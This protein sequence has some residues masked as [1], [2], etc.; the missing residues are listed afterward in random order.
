SQFLS[1]LTPKHCDSPAM[2]TFARIVP[3]LG[4]CLVANGCASL[5][6]G[7]GDE[8]ETPAIALPPSDARAPSVD[9]T[10]L[11]TELAQLKAENARLRTAMKALQRAKIAAEQETTGAAKTASGGEPPSAAAASPAPAAGPKT[12]VVAAADADR[13]LADAPQVA[14]APR[15]VQPSI[16]DT[17]PAFENEAAGDIK[18]A[19]VLYGVHLASYRMTDEAREGWRKLQR[20][21]PDELGLLEPRVEQV[22]VN[23]RGVFLRLIGGGF[24]SE[25]KAEA[26]CKRLKS[27]NLYCAVASFNGDRLSLAGAA[28]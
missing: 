7:G 15:L 27:K 28:G 21:N 24:S 2:N 20:E 23:G 22:S 25:D 1:G 6:I 26:L 10:K 8:A 5:G 14:G 19:S 18:V 3:A 16:A 9:E 12:A 11:R 13:A 4:A 17:D